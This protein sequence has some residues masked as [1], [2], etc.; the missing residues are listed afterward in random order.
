MAGDP[1]ADFA[2][3]LERGFIHAL[4][5]PHAQSVND[6]ADE[7]M[8]V[9]GHVTTRGASVVQSCVCRD[10]PHTCRRHGHRA[11][12]PDWPVARQAWVRGRGSMIEK[13]ARHL[14]A[15]FLSSRRSD[16]LDFRRLRAFCA[17]LDDELH[18]LA[19]SQRLEAAGLDFREVREQI[20]GAI[21]RRDEAE[22]FGVVEPLDSTLCHFLVP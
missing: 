22:T 17:L 20:L 11:E 2:T 4:L 15:L 5:S 3:R 1:V 19:F 12:G 8:L 14:A 13:K 7:A 6:Q 21:F 18:F 9:G 10:T 16:D